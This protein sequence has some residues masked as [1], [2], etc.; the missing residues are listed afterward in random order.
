MNYDRAKA[1]SEMF[2]AIGGFTSVNVGHHG[3]YET[4]DDEVKADGKWCVELWSVN[5][6]A[7]N[8][9]VTIV[10]DPISP[11]DDAPRPPADM[12][13]AKRIARLAKGKATE[14]DRAAFARAAAERAV[15]AE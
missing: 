4:L 9:T 7:G 11:T 1:V 13:E 8:R 10:R 6:K 14:Q 3:F 12:A 15:N 2:A 5:P